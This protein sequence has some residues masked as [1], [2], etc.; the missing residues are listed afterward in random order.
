MYQQDIG[1][2]IANY[3]IMINE[4]NIKAMDSLKQLLNKCQQDFTTDDFGEPVTDNIYELLAVVSD[5][6]RLI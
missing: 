6:N 2:E 3:G 4:G 1:A 5:D